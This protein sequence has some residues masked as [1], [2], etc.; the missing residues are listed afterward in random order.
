MCGA[1]KAVKASLA[2]EKDVQ[3]CVLR[4]YTSGESL[5]FKVTSAPLEYEGKRFVVLTLVD[6]GSEKQ[7]MALER[8]FLHDLNNTL[9]C[10]VGYSELLQESISDEFREI[11]DK[12]VYAAFRMDDEIQAQ[13]QILRAENG[14]LDLELTEVDLLELTHDIVEDLG[15]VRQFQGI[16][17]NLAPEVE[18]VVVQADTGIVS[19]VMRNMLKNA[20]E[21]SKPGDEIAVG[22]SGEGDWANFWTHNPGHIPEEVQLRIFDRF[23]STKGASRGLGTY[24]MRLLT[25]RYLKG[26]VSFVSSQENGTVFTARIPTKP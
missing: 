18:R 22:C 5:N 14:E 2:G 20:L 15:T 6:I 1:F 24:S 11:A 12:L 4:Q 9:A 16:S 21:A 26:N 13:R 17:I 19:R 7:K 25:E 10:V 23:F 8:V 3:E